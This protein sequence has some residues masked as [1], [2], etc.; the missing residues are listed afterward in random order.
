M[1]H[2]REVGWRGEA[3]DDRKQAEAQHLHPINNAAPQSNKPPATLREAHLVWRGGDGSDA[4]A[5]VPA[6]VD[7]F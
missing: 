1:R 6:L 3:A 4:V 2:C 5:A 7:A